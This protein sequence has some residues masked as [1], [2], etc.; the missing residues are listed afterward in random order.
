MQNKYFELNVKK[1]GHYNGQRS[2]CLVS[3]NC[4]NFMADFLWLHTTKTN[5]QIETI[6]KSQHLFVN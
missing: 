4:S 1:R 2:Q 5:Y 3:M 6:M